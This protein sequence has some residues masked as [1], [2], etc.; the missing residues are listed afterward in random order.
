MSQAPLSPIRADPPRFF[1]RLMLHRHSDALRVRQNVVVPK[2]Q[3]VEALAP[4][5]ICSAD[6]QFRPAVMLTAIDLDDQLGLVTDKIG[7]I[8]SDWNLATKLAAIQ[9]TLTEHSPQLGVRVC[10]LAPQRPLRL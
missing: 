5:E 3:D 10:H 8:P 7:D 2:A 9:L 6:L 4:Q 1:D